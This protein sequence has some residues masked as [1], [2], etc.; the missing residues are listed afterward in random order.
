MLLRLSPGTNAW[1]QWILP[2]E[3]DVH[4]EVLPGRLKFSGHKN[5]APFESAVVVFGAA[6]KGNQR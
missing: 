1:Q 3:Y 6:V 2:E 5:A 4:Y